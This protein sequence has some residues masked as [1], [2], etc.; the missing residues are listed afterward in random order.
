MEAW[1]ATRR[2]PGRPSVDRSTTIEAGEHEERAAGEVCL[3]VID[4]R[5]RPVPVRRPGPRRAFLVGGGAPASSWPAGPRRWFLTPLADPITPPHV[6]LRVLAGAPLR[7]RVIDAA[8]NARPAWIEVFDGQ[9]VTSGGP[10][11]PGG[12][13]VETAPD[14]RSAI[15]AVPAG[16]VPVEVV[17][18]AQGVILRGRAR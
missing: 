18:P 13:A 10:L 17:A 16:G 14:G 15:P 11:W 1:P 8:G 9:M 12:P 4:P 7:G 3:R 5:D 2:A 6:L